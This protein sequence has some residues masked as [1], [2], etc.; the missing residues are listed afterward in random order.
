MSVTFLGFTHNAY[1][2]AQVVHLLVLPLM[3]VAVVVVTS[4]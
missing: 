3:R 1:P 4:R 2:M